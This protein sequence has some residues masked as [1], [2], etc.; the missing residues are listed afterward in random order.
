MKNLKTK[1]LCIAIVT[2][3]CTLAAEAQITGLDP[4]FSTRS[5]MLNQYTS[6]FICSP[7]NGTIIQNIHIDDDP[8]TWANSDKFQYYDNGWVYL[9]EETPTT[10]MQ[11]GKGYVLQ[12]GGNGNYTAALLPSEQEFNFSGGGANGGTP[13]SVGVIDGQFNLLGNPYNNYLNLD[14]FLLNSNNST[15]VRGPIMLWSHNTIISSNNNNPDDPGSQ[16]RNSANDFALYNVLGGVAAGR[17]ISTSPENATYTGI[18]TPNGRLCFGTGFGVYSIG[19]GDVVYNDIMR[20]TDNGGE[21]QSFRGVLSANSSNQRSE[22]SATTTNSTP[23][24]LALSGKNRIWVNIEQ[25][26]I[27]TLGQNFNQLKQLLVGFADGATDADNDRV[28]DAE[29]VT[30][31]S[32]IEF[33]SLASNSTKHLAIQGRANNSFTG[34]D[35]FQLGYHV[36]TA[37]NY[38]FTAT[39][40]GAFEPGQKQYF[41][42]DNGVPHD[43]PY[44]VSLAAN[45]S[46]ETRFRITFGE[47]QLAFKLIIEGYYDTSLNQMRPVRV[48]QGT[49]TNLNVAELIDVE[50]RDQALPYTLR[51]QE[52]GL[53]LSTSGNAAITSSAMPLG[54]Y[55]LVVKHRNAIKTCSAIPITIANNQIYD[56]TIAASQAYGGNQ[57]EVEPGVFAIY[58]GDI[59]QDESVDNLDSFQLFLD[60]ENSNFGDLATDLNGDG[61]V[62][63]TDTDFFFTNG[64]NSIFSIHPF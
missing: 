35:F 51:Y 47:R 54:T 23:N 27:P 37:G 59:N 9:P 62:D 38:T 2:I 57:V 52:L 5:Q 55:Y 6:V 28:F 40:D 11:P 3:G 56:F 41:I 45:E 25:G 4:L 64:F 26:T 20:R 61:G 18:Q 10:T 13:I 24:V 60:I 50:L 44:T 17:Q 31:Q 36:T 19:T 39:A 21:D 49:S 8:V 42:W 7:N 1:L 43:F 32:R 34:E 30:V 16:Y 12:L 29:T 63:N 33:Y 48:N 58:S 15:K 53:E 22:Q 14:D 46:S